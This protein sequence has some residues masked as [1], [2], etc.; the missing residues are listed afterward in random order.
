MTVLIIEEFMISN[1]KELAALNKFEDIKYSELWNFTSCGTLLV[2]ENW[3]V[4]VYLLESFHIQIY[5]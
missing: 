4:E 5:F 3:K 2:V 1:W